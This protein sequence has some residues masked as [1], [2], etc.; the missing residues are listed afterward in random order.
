MLNFV[1]SYKRP[2]LNQQI[3][4]APKNRGGLALPDLKKYYSAAVLTAF[5]KRYSPSYVAAWK[6]LMAEPMLP[7]LFKEVAWQ[8]P[9]HR[10][11]SFQ[12][13]TL[14]KTLLDEWDRF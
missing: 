12:P 14:N 9:T 7:Y 6:D 10:R 5:L 3:L 2:R 1:W 8:A 4:C 13:S 11:F